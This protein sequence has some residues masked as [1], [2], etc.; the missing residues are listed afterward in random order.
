MGPRHCQA[1]VQYIPSSIIL[2]FSWMTI[3]CLLLSPQTS[4]SFLLAYCQLMTFTGKKKQSEFLPA[5]T[6]KH[7]S[8]QSLHSLLLCSSCVLAWQGHHSS[9]VPASASS[10]FPLY[11]IIPISK[12]RS[13][14]QSKNNPSLDPKASL[15]Y[16]TFLYC[17]LQQNPP[18]ELTVLAVSVFY[19]PQM[20][21]NQILV[22]TLYTKL[23]FP[24]HSTKNALVQVTNKRIMLNPISSSVI[25]LLICLISSILC[26]STTLK[27]K[28]TKK[29]R[30]N[31]IRE[32]WNDGGFV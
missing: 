29:L 15:N 28:Q 27:N 31:I 32:V 26:P 12:T 24:I 3:Y 18:K 13:F 6:T 16:C 11:S 5:P 14:P 30:K 1:I 17:P 2:P 20:H 22:L 10:F 8:P 7:L 19:S 4:S 21:S 9:N 25:S 23:L